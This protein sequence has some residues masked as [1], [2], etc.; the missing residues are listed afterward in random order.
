[1]NRQIEELRQKKRSIEEQFE[2]MATAIIRDELGEDV[3]YDNFSIT[4]H[5]LPD[6]EDGTLT[7]NASAKIK[8]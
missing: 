7:F 4:L 3:N 1:M 5:G 2:Q 6:S 8:I